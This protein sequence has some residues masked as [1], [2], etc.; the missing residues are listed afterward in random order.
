MSVRTTPSLQGSPRDR[1]TVLDR[2]AAAA[3]RR[4]HIQLWSCNYAPE[5]SGIAPLSAAW[6]QAMLAR[7]HRVEVIAAHPHY[8]EPIWGR[9]TRPYREKRDGVPVLRLPLWAGHGSSVQRMRQELSYA[10]WLG[11]CAPAL[12]RADVIVAVSPSFPGLLPAMMAARARHVPWAMW[13]QDILPDGALTTGLVPPGP[14]LNAA[15]RF[16]RSAYRSAAR[17]FVISEAFRRNLLGKGV[18]GDKVTCIYNPSPAPVAHARR[19]VRTSDTTRLLVMGNIGHSQGLAEFVAALER[20]DVLSQTGTVLRIAGAGVARADVERAI[21]SDRVQMLGLLLGDAMEEELASATLG[22]VTQRSGI[23]EFN[24]P[25]KLMNYMAHSLPVLAVVAPGSETAR[26][27]R[28]SGAGWVAD[29]G[30]LDDLPETL[31]RILGDREE[32]AA[33]GRTA[34]AFAHEHFTPERVA[35]RFERELVGLALSAS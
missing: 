8:P 33:R 2:A 27:V 11:A 26:I 18:P 15:R 29:A 34:L 32:L 7:G 5:P 28:D 31:R 24:L 6:A 3:D 25:S 16:E 30:A 10:A 9:R 23:S 4:L 35:E 14:V 12:G 13:L 21:R 22:I 19:F 17:V 1:G 20:S